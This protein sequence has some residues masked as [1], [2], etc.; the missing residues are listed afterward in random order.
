ME[1]IADI[2]ISTTGSERD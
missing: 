1:N 2:T